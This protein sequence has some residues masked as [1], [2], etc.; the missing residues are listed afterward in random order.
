VEDHLKSYP[1]DGFLFNV[2]RR[3][4]LG[5]MLTR[6]WNRSGVPGCFCEYC[7]SAGR[8]RGADPERARFGMEKIW[9]FVQETARGETRPPDGYFVTLLRL[10]MQHPEALMR[11]QVWASAMDSLRAE[12]YG[13]V[14]A[15]DPAKKIGW[16]IYH[17][18]MFSPFFRAETDYGKFRRFSDYVKPVIYPVCAGVR[19]ARYVGLVNQVIMRDT[20]VDQTLR[21]LYAVMGW[22]EAS[23]DELPDRG[24]SSEAVAREVR[25]VVAAVQD[26]VP[27]Y[28][29]IDL[30]IPTAHQ[31]RVATVE[32][33]EQAT[34]AS[35]RAG[36]KGLVISRL[37]HEMDLDVLAGVGRALKSLGID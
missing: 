26:E 4:P 16:H 11:N 24:F 25:R 28:P 18:G 27:V 19:F 7:R 23:L 9:D 6:M 20:D 2:E 31:G 21:L 22:D 32:D 35:Y 10:V 8:E 1:I 34:L 12:M 15:I 37:Y 3:G 13:V 14:K 36:G 5:A 29:G 17:E 33:V 30:G